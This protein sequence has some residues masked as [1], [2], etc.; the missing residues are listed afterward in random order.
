MIMKFF[1]RQ[2]ETF[3]K[4]N[5]TTKLTL[6]QERNGE[7]KKYVINNVFELPSNLFKIIISTTIPDKNF[8][9]HNEHYFFNMNYG[10]I[11]HLKKLIEI[12]QKCESEKKCP[13]ERDIRFLLSD[14]GVSLLSHYFFV[15]N[16][17][18]IDGIINTLFGTKEL[19]LFDYQKTHVDGILNS[20]LVHPGVL[21]TSRTGSGKTYTTLAIAKKLNLRIFC[22]CPN[23]IYKKWKELSWEFSGRSDVFNYNKFSK[24]INDSGYFNFDGGKYNASEKFINLVK[25]GILLVID[26]AHYIKNPRSLRSMAIYSLI[27]CIMANPGKSRIILLSATPFSKVKGKTGYINMI[28]NIGLCGSEDDWYEIIPGVPPIMI[29]TGYNYLRQLIYK[30]TGFLMPLADRVTNMRKTLFECFV[31]SIKP[32]FFHS[33]NCTFEDH[34]VSTKNVFVDTSKEDYLKAVQMLDILEENLSV[35]FDEETNHYVT[36]ISS[37]KEITNAITIL[38]AIK[39]KTIEE[40]IVEKLVENFKNH[41]IVFCNRKKSV[42]TLLEKLKMYDPMYIIGNVKME[43]RMEIVKKFNHPSSEHRLLIVNIDTV[44]E[45]LDF[46]DKTGDFPRISFVFPNYSIQKLIQGSGR[47]SRIS[48]KSDVEINF[49]YIKNAGQEVHMLDNIR[50]K[51]N[52]LVQ[53]TTEE[54]IKNIPTN[55]F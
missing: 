27:K 8:F 55:Y 28:K 53:A 48:T 5:N 54:N 41:V 19:N 42:F 21:D 13:S 3:E 9:I 12:I 1:F 17:S 31:S 16:E 2:T 47:I 14:T 18:D 15:D 22:I 50:N 26:E 24:K 45:G 38:E 32:L 7:M 39:V 37:L 20:Y 52:I 6:L 33:M 25:S 34:N 35:K 43:K 36:S 29:P 10:S 11:K 46:D 23:N 51:K 30:N 49:I 4:M 40:K 44:C